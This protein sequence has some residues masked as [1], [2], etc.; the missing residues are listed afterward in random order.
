MS[1]IVYKFL[2]LRVKLQVSFDIEKC[3]IKISCQSI[4][5]LYIEEFSKGIYS[6]FIFNGQHG[7]VDIETFLILK[8]F[9][10]LLC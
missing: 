5:F 2:F 7:V 6:N 9:L 4:L 3:I 10:F 1:Y 8:A